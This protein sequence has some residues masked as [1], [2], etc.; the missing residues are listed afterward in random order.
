MPLEMPE[1]AARDWVRSAIATSLNL[2]VPVRAEAV[3]ACLEWARDPA[4]HLLVEEDPRYPALLREIPDP[5]VLLFAKGRLELLQA[6]AIAIVGSRNATPRGL[7]DARDFAGEFSRR[8]L[9]VVSGLARGIDAAAHTGALAFAGSSIAVLGT[10]PDRI[11]PAGNA[12]LARELAATGCIVTEFPVGT[13]PMARN[14]PQRN[15]IISGLARGVLVVE[16]APRS[17]SLVTAH[18]AASQGREV[19]ALPGSIHATLSKGCHQLIREGAKLVEDA[20]HVIEEIPAWHGLGG[21]SRDEP[22]PEAR[23]A[24]SLLDA[25]GFAPVSVDTV[26]GLTGLEASTCI[27]RLVIL[28]LEGHVRRLAGGLF[29]RSR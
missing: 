11:Y 21:L 23:C 16:A 6:E 7:Q 24:D 27:E 17:G 2:C 4:H 10:G 15:R 19:F 13:T 29:Q 18:V 25:M 14:F 5:P 22:S 9:C 8:G 28:E 26:A 1:T 20:E 3:D 12:K